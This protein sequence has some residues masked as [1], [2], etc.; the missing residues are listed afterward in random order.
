MTYFQRFSLKKNRT[1]ALCLGVVF[2]TLCASVL[3]LRANPVLQPLGDDIEY[4]SLAA[5]LAAG[6]GF[7]LDGAAPS[8]ARPPLFSGLLGAW[9][10]LTGSSSLYS[11]GL[12][13]AL[14]HSL[15]CGAAFLLF[16]EVFGLASLAL[17]LSLW[18]GLMP[19]HLSRLALVLQE[20]AIMFFT[21]AAILASLRALRAPSGGAFVRSG[22][23]W[24]LCTLSK[25]VSWFGPPLVVL[26][27]YLAARPSFVRRHALLLFLAFAAVLSPWI[28]RNYSRFG[29]LIVVNAQ[30]TGVL[31]YNLTRAY[32]NVFFSNGTEIEEG[33]RLVKELKDQNLT[34]EQRNGEMLKFIKKNAR[35]FIFGR[36]ASSVVYFTFP[37]FFQNWYK[38]TAAP[39]PGLRKIIAYGWWLLLTIPLYLV[40]LYRCV[41]LAKGSLSAPLSFL[42]VFYLLYWGQYAL[43]WADPRYSVPVYPLLLCL[44][45]IPA[46][47]RRTAP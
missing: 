33:T 27:Q 4:Y 25:S 32:K 23:A 16:V 17:G 31:E 10:Y 45:P 36:I 38:T 46:R 5:N 42:L 14:M 12:F 43:A 13:Q 47:W 22:A 40:L 39:P 29:R 18:L 19:P 35:Y 7:S 37:D 6:K 11:A 34:E 28:V 44:L 2:L 20:P 9:F 41:Q 24:G 15:A 3:F 26:Y 1:P 30:G 8:A 21:T